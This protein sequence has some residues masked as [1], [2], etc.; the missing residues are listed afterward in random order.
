MHLRYT[1]L[2]ISLVLFTCLL[3]SQAWTDPP[4]PGL[5]DDITLYYDAS[6][7]NKE[8]E[9]VD[10][11]YAFAGLLT[12]E[13]THWS[14]WKYVKTGW[15][16]NDPDL[17]MEKVDGNTHRLS[18]NIKQFFGVPQNEIV[19]A[20]VFIFHDTSCELVGRAEDGS[21][22]IVPLEIEPPLYVSHEFTGNKLFVYSQTD[23]YGF[24][25]YREDIVRI[26][27]H[28]G[29]DTTFP[30]SLSLIADPLGEAT[31]F[32]EE[33]MLYFQSGHVEIKIRKDTLFYAVDIYNEELMS[34]GMMLHDGSGT[35]FSFHADENTMWFGGGSRAL[36]MNRA[37]YGLRMYN[38]P[39]YGYS[40]WNDQ[41][42]ICIPTIVSSEGYALYM[43]NANPGY[44]SLGS[45][46]PGEISYKAESGPLS[47]FIM[48]PDKISDIMEPFTYLTGRQPLPPLWSMGYI[49]SRF[50]Y[51][52]ESE[53]Y[54][55][56]EE[57]QSQGFPMDAII[58]DL[59]WMGGVEYMGNLSWDMIRFPDPSGMID[60]FRNRGIKSICITEPYFTKNGQYYNYLN[61]LGYFTKNSDGN[62]YVLNDFWAGPSAMI[63][64]TKEQAKDWYWGRYLDI[65]GDGVE[66][67]WTD[68]G[69]PEASPDDM[70]YFEGS[71]RE[72]HQTYNLRWSELIYENFRNTF[73]DKRLVNISRSGYAGMQ[74]FSTMPWSGDVA[75]DFEGLRAQMPIMLG[76]GLS[77]VGFM[78]CDVGGFVGDYYP[79]LYTRWQ[80][81]GA[82]IPVMRAHGT[83]VPPEP[84]YYPEP[85]K[86]AVKE[87][88]LLRYRF[89]PYNYTLAWENCMT[90]KPLA[91]PLFFIDPALGEVDDQFL[92][93]DDI[94]I[95]PVIEPE[96][97]SRWVV[98][99]QGKWIDFNY[100]SSHE[101][102]SGVNRYSPYW[103]N[104]LPVFVRAGSIIPTLRQI[105]N[106][107]EYDG[108]QYY[109]MCYPDED[110][111]E[112]DAVIYMDD[113]KSQT[114]ITNSEFRIININ[115]TFLSGNYEISLYAQGDG[116]AGED[117]NKKME[118]DVLRIKEKPGQIL[119]NG[120]NIAFANS[121]EEYENLNNSAFWSDEIFLVK[122][123]WDVNI[124]GSLVIEGIDIQ[125]DMGITEN[126]PMWELKVYPNPINESSVLYVSG[127]LP[128][129][130]DI[131][132][133][134]HTGRIISDTEKNFPNS[135]SF[136]IS[137][138]EIIPS[139]LSPGSYFIRI[140][141]PGGEN[142]IAIIIF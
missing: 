9:G 96:A 91:R 16:E 134:D 114:A 106:T 116:Y 70:L 43:E 21:D 71:A 110:I 40:M 104:G 3:Q 1:I 76:M 44:L 118:F 87:S 53:A 140:S 105:Y 7:G 50:G 115:S 98:L 38:R 13:S 136:R 128:G 36:P 83:G 26:S 122:V 55:V 58:F 25:P 72:I 113:G 59:Q 14:D 97:E 139:R 142:R 119:Y 65:F 77:G 138:N 81:M 56:V 46:E 37:G 69:E 27:F 78:H 12:S 92:W 29:N 112:S 88:I 107:S 127:A 48:A 132:L 28:P 109:M 117:G 95:A 75:R 62:S 24:T 73:P 4:K 90:G 85:Y 133:L 45:I 86:T 141:G 129:L 120:L 41:L 22:I 6:Q 101:G 94:M 2:T 49:Q 93:G 102:G 125:E 60:D 137:L 82:F 5:D 67:L 108:N 19:T 54:E 33:D 84:I 100:L 121:Y 99:P 63:D 126:M 32:E 20:M 66:G 135:P 17:L 8:L 52:N 64:I 10:I 111:Y 15:C 57:M 130:Y 124:V 35:Y 61:A 123:T 131:R 68:L 31:F 51:E 30:G 89:L 79:E 23:A 80:Q 42:N 39:K 47:C 74:R 103:S 11:V 18:F 34:M